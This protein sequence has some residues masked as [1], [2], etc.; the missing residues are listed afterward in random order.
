M[1]SMKYVREYVAKRFSLHIVIRIENG[2]LFRRLWTHCLLPFCEA[3]KC[4]REK[5]LAVS[6]ENL[7]KG[8]CVSYTALVTRFSQGLSP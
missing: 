3:Y 4:S 5:A 6:E 7:G 1:Y 2:D 8:L